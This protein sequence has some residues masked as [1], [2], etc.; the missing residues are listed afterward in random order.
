MAKNRSSSAKTERGI[1]VT[2]TPFGPT[3]EQLAA[4]GARVMAQASVRK[5]LG[6]GKAR[7]LYVEALDDEDQAKRATPRPPT[8][9]RATR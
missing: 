9:F 1:T 6:R 8:R 7:L 4:I 5:F 2:V 3:T